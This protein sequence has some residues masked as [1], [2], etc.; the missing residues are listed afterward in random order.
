[1]GKLTKRVLLGIAAIGIAAII[2]SR[3]GLTRLH[4]P[5]YLMWSLSGKPCPVSYVRKFIYYDQN[6]SALVK[7]LSENEILRRFPFAKDADSM[8]QDDYRRFVLDYVRNDEKY[9]GKRIKMFWLQEDMRLAIV[10][11]D[12]KGQELHLFKG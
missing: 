4:H 1:M 5:E 2:I 11:V 3:I 7:G 6:A 10:V 9:R 12:S 8:A